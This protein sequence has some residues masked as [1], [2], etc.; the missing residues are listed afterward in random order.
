[1]L[2]PIN[3]NLQGR[4]C[5]V[6][7]GGRTALRKIKLL[8][9]AGAAVTVTAPEISEEI[10]ELTASE[11]VTVKEKAA[12]PE[13]IKDCFLVICA[14]SEP[15]V[16]Q[17]IAAAAKKDGILVNLAAPPLDEGDFIVPASVCAAD[18]QISF[19][20]SGKSPE[21]ARR[22]KQRYFDE[23]YNYGEFLK[24]LEP[25]REGLRERLHDSDACTEIWRRLLDDETME[26]AAQGRFDEAEERIT[27]ALVGFRTKS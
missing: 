22:L 9:R 25:Y 12:S 1:M 8:L 14:A 11:K 27:D 18:L 26:L 16:N 15:T 13:D 5:A 23:I 24:I 4:R 6:I 3:I 2:Y 10:K 21:L 20:T 19:S 7:G 17:I